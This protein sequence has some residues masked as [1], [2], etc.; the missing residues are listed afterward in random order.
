MRA[1]HSFRVRTPELYPLLG[2]GLFQPPL[3]ICIPCEAGQWE[4]LRMELFST[5]PALAE[6]VNKQELDFHFSTGGPWRN[7]EIL[8]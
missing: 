2:E 3:E 5:L 6:L 4:R 7:T 1:P 8:A